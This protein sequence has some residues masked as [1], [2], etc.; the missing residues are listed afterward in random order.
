ME[1]D[2]QT[3]TYDRLLFSLLILR[4]IIIIFFSLYPLFNT[5]QTIQCHT[6][7]L[8]YNVCR[9]SLDKTIDFTKE[10]IS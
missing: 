1:K 6:K 3:V 4:L 2:E 10:C 8:K 7:I 5:D 9:L